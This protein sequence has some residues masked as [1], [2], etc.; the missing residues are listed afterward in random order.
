VRGREKAY[1]GAL[2]FEAHDPSPLRLTATQLS[3]QNRRVD[4]QDIFDAKGRLIRTYVGQVTG[5]SETINGKQVFTIVYAIQYDDDDEEM[6]EDVDWE[7]LKE[8]LRAYRTF[9][10]EKEKK[11]RNIRRVNSARGI[12]TCAYCGDDHKQR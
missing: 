2:G 7:T 5:N 10:E 8:R 9:I 1:E 12:V 11:E 3:A 6:E 4:A